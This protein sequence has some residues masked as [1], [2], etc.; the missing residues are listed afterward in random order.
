[1]RL[2]QIDVQLGQHD[3]A[4]TRLDDLR[5]QGKGRRDAEQLAVLTLEEQGKKA[6][7]RHASRR[8]ARVSRAARSW[9]G[10]SR[11]AGQGRQ[12]GRGRPDPGSSSSPA[13]PTT[14]RW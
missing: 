10:S 8:H 11:P 4:L 9:S 13:N 7:A 5:T 12:A 14:R 3:R 6:E 2:A 1:M